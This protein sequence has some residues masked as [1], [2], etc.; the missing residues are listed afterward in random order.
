M[1][2]ELYGPCP[3]E[4][5]EVRKISDHEWRIGDGRR[6][7]Q[8]PEKVLGYIQERDGGFEVLTMGARG[9]DVLFADWDAAVASFTR[10]GDRGS[11]RIR[12]WKR[13][14]S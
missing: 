14:Q 11:T 4:Q 10:S 12:P 9:S 5:L 2:Y 6:D 1:L 3:I 7:E 13:R 8:S